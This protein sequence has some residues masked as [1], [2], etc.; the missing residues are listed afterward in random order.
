MSPDDLILLASTP[1]T[2]MGNWVGE[3][4]KYQL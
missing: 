4:Q 2:E 1:K 3:M